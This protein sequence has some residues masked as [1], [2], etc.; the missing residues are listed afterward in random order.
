MNY[1]E[2]MNMDMEEEDGLEVTRYEYITHAITRNVVQR[3]ISVAT[4]N[5]PALRTNHSRLHTG[6]SHSPNE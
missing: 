2:D 1:A 5:S 3:L 6:P 4:V